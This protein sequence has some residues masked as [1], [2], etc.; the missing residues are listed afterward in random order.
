MAAADPADAESRRALADGHYGLAD[1]YRDLGKMAEAKATL[2]LA[3]ELHGHLAAA[4]PQ[5]AA[6]R[7][8]IAA[9]LIGLGNIENDLGRPAD[10]E[11]AFKKS[12]GLLEDP[13]ARLSGSDRIP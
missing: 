9:A 11:D 7:R 12:L 6:P 2:R 13:H 8:G 10:A 4:D 3:A 1:L 5:A